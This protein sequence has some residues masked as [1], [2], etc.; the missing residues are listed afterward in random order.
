[1]RWVLLLRA[2]NLGPNNKLAMKDLTARARATSG[3]PR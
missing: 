1:M 2:V 3:T